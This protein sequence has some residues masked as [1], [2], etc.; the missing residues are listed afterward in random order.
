MLAELNTPVLVGG[1]LDQPFALQRVEPVDGGLVRGD[2]A[3]DLD[4]T[5]EGGLAVFTEVAFDEREHGVLLF[6][7]GKSRHGDTEL[8]SN[9]A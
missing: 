2:L 3:V 5:D 6:G 1:A 7:E 9:V 4:F 8:R